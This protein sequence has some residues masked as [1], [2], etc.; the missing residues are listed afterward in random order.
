MR[1]WWVMIPLEDFADVTLAIKDTDDH[2]DYDDHGDHNDLDE[3]EN[4]WTL[5]RMDENIWWWMKMD[6]HSKIILQNLENTRKS[7][8]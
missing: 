3:H 6:K 4:G 7:R 8:K 5:M 1:L 2:D